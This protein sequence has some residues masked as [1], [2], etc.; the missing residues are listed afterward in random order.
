MEVFLGLEG[1]H[2]DCQADLVIDG[3]L[4]DTVTWRKK[5]RVLRAHT[6]EH[7]I[8]KGGRR[9]PY[10]S[11]LKLAELAPGLSYLFDPPAAQTTVGTIDIRVFKANSNST[12]NFKHQNKVPDYNEQP[13]LE[14]SDLIAGTAGIEPTHKIV[15]SAFEE[16][17]ESKRKALR[18]N[19][20]RDRLGLAP[21]AVF[22]FLYRG[23]KSLN[24]A[25]MLST[26][27]ISPVP[28]NAEISDEEQPKSGE[29]G[30][31]NDRDILG[32]I[33]STASKP[34]I[35]AAAVG[36]IQVSTE[37]TRVNELSTPELGN[38]LDANE[39]NIVSSLEGIALQDILTAPVAHME[40]T[41]QILL[42]GTNQNMKYSTV[43]ASEALENRIDSNHVADG[44]FSGRIG[45]TNE[46]HVIEGGG[47]G[48]GHGLSGPVAI[49]AGKPEIPLIEQ[50][51]AE[52]A[53]SFLATPKTSAL[54]SVNTKSMFGN[55]EILP[56][57]RKIPPHLGIS[58]PWSFPL[59][60]LRH[61]RSSATEGS[62]P[63][64]VASMPT[65]DS[66][67]DEGLHT[68]LF[69]TPDSTERLK[70]VRILRSDTRPR[71][72]LN[73]TSN[74]N[75]DQLAPFPRT[76]DVLKRSFGSPKLTKEEL[77]A[78]PRPEDSVK[79]IKRRKIDIEALKADLKRLAARK[80]DSARR[81][82]EAS[83]KREE[84]ERILNEQYEALEQ[85]RWEILNSIAAD[86]DAEEE[87]LDGIED[88][89]K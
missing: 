61:P 11:P 84:H 70:S 50:M 44:S 75:S 28:A 68:P 33:S 42:A 77:Q 63:S 69:L 29:D 35:A 7:G 39:R 60:E 76:Q 5:L 4:R 59:D 3:I 64:P 1:L 2:D 34:Q 23:Q 32:R 55:E 86:Y 8:W 79:A 15:P 30:T 40:A 31:G 82:E 43:H 9:K 38:V 27:T 87:Y 10:R 46:T 74:I 73:L 37:G 48:H 62:S 13:N 83:R 71:N 52:S 26:H 22:R 36:G 53:V 41:S 81:V 16:L 19:F 47:L 49:V 88:D 21:W 58:R 67:A 89:S 24:D 57:G 17:S 56:V 78:S 85:E 20:A 12:P 45:T 6:F 25:E 14:D 54:S 51:E 65:Q 80:A 18:S 66:G 72:S